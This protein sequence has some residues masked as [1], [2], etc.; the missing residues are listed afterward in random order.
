MT[1]SAIS[2]FKLPNALP[3]ELHKCLC[4]LDIA[5]ER[6]SIEIFENSTKEAKDLKVEA[7]EQP[8]TSASEASTLTLPDNF[9]QKLHGLLCSLDIDPGN[10]TIKI[11]ESSTD[12]SMILL[13]PS[14][15]PV[16]AVICRC[17]SN[18]C[19]GKIPCPGPPGRCWDCR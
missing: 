14:T 15:Q 2:E 10:V 19:G 3:E 6:L 8:C 13:S 5:P 9:P 11:S 16:K 18:R 12:G 4:A 1:N 7:V 17:Y